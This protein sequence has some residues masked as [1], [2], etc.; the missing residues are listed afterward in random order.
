MGIDG[1]GAVYDYVDAD[2]VEEEGVPHCGHSRPVGSPWCY[3][4]QEEAL[5]FLRLVLTC[6]GHRCEGGPVAWAPL[7]REFLDR[8]DNEKGEE[9]C[10]D[11]R[12]TEGGAYIRRP[13]RSG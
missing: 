8:L 10:D 12:K 5:K 6:N 11:D 4:C 3:D 13:A 9:D 2:L 7:I 1:T